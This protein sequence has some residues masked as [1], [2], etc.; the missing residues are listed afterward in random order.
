ML[1]YECRVHSDNHQ[2]NVCTKREL[3]HCLDS[4]EKSVEFGSLSNVSLNV[5]LSFE[6]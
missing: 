1:G 5:P 3:F 2:L 4:Y 6:H